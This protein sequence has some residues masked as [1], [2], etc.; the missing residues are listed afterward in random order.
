MGLGWGRHRIDGS[1]DDG[2]DRARMACK[3][4][5]VGG[6]ASIC[7]RLGECDVTMGAT[8]G[9]R[10]RSKQNM[11]RTGEWGRIRASSIE[12]VGPIEA[13]GPISAAH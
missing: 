8:D 13:G 12:A 1:S 9:I 7:V 3:F 10:S 2:R 5:C 4:V 11:A 6:A